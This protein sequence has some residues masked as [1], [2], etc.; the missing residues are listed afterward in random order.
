MRAEIIA[1]GSELLSFNRLETNSLHISSRLK[2][3]GIDVVRKVVVGDRESEIGESLSLALKRSDVVAVTGGLGPTND[4]ITR[5]VVGR[6][7]GRRLREDEKVVNDL[8]QRYERFG[9]K[10]TP[11][12]R[13]QGLVPEGAELLPNPNGTA[14]GLFLEAEGALIFL[15]PGP[16]RE[17]YP[18]VENHVLPMI[19]EKR[20]SKVVPSRILKV[21]GEAE[22]KV[23]SKVESIYKEFRE[24]ETTILSSP[25]VISLYFTWRGEQ[26]GESAERVLDELA[27]RVRQRLGKSV[28]SDREEELSEAVGRLLTDQSL[29]V[30]T[31]ESCTGGLIGKLFTDVPGSSAYYL[32]SVV[33]YSN[34]VKEQML[35]VSH[36][37][38]LRDGAVSE[39]VARQMAIGVAER[40]G[41]DI[42]LATTGIAGPTGGSEEKPVGTVCLGLSIGE[43]IKVRTL[44]LPGG[45]EVIRLRTSNLALDWLRREIS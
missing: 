6:V 28:Y 44:H 11:N 17:L 2:T 12:N 35:G 39:S 13:K 41:S 19:Q 5:E 24:V 32:G 42:G 29:T 43:Q 10:L 8:R 25:G 45:R 36:D 16:P 21:G 4:D 31:A 37:L 9:L 23:D 14:P 15:L 38:L 40:I 3:L 22:S 20:H 7:L 34:S 30:A 1:V 18:M 33:S 27:A 26:L